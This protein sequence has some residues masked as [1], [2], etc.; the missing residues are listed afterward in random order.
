MLPK[1]KVQNLITKHSEIEKELSSGDV[2]KKN[3]AEKS[4]EYSEL[5]DIINCLLYTSPSPRD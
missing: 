5:N 1:T 4:K 2:D 3:F